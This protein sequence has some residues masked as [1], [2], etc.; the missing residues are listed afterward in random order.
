MYCE[1]S[2]D[3]VKINVFLLQDVFLELEEKVICLFL[4]IKQTLGFA[5]LFWT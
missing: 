3:I 2:D 4:I 1:L 5:L